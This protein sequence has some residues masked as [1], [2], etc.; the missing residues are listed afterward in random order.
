MS[1]TMVPLGTVIQ[2]VE[3]FKLTPEARATL[4][5]AVARQQDTEVT[6]TGGLDTVVTV[7]LLDWLPQDEA[8]RLRTTLGLSEPFE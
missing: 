4:S 5:E 1:G 3:G 2:V 8:S 6:L 7:R